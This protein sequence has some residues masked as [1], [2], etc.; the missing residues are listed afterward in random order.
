MEK[1]RVVVFEKYLRITWY[2]CV[3]AVRNETCSNYDLWIVIP[4]PLIPHPI[5]KNNRSCVCVH[6][7]LCVC[8]VVVAV[9]VVKC[10]NRFIFIKCVLYASG[11]SK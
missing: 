9:I 7:S 3:M 5:Q 6:M 1:E 11:T 4:H 8:V 2:D 10:S